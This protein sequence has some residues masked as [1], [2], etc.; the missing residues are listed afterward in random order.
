MIIHFF[1]LSKLNHSSSLSWLFS[2]YHMFDQNTLF[3][4]A[5]GMTFPLCFFSVISWYT[6]FSSW[7]KNLFTRYYSI[8]CAYQFV[9]SS[10]Q[11]MF[12]FLDNNLKPFTFTCYSVHFLIF[13]TFYSRML[14]CLLISLANCFILLFH[15]GSS[16]SFCLSPQD[17]S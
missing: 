17:L 1:S 2:K 15:Y 3:S 4:L 10:F 14:I 5:S 13:L 7:S 12:Y 16:L 9:S 8:L 11:Y 6:L